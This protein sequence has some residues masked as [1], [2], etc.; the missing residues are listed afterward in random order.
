MGSGKGLTSIAAAEELAK[1]YGLPLEAIM[2]AS[3][4]SNY[5]KEM[6]RHLDHPLEDVR[7]RSYEK[8]VRDKQ[9]NPE[10]FVVLDEAQRA[11][12][13][14]TQLSQ[15]LAKQVQH[16]PA[17]LLLSGTPAYN[18]PV[19]AAR[20]LNLAAGKQ[21]LPDDPYLFNKQFV[22][23]KK[24]SPPLL[25]RIRGMDPAYIPE[26][27]NVDKIIQAAK[28]Y[29]D[30]HPGGGEGFPTSSEEDVEVPMSKEQARMYDFHQGKLPW[31]L[32]V[33][34]RYGMPMSKQESKQLNAFATAI[35]QT[36]NTPRPYIKNMTDE[37]EALNSPKIQRAAE[38]IEKR[39][40]ADP[41]YRGY[42]YSNFLDAGLLPLSRALKGKGIEHGI[43]HGGLSQ[44]EK[45]N[46][47]D[48]YNA[49]K[50]KELLLSSSG[51]EGLDLKGTKHI[52][53]LDPHFNQSKLDQVK[54]RGI[55][56]GSHA[57]L[58][59][60]ERNVQVQRFYSTMPK[61]FFNRVGIGK[62]PMA[63][64][65]YLQQQSGRKHELGQQMM[66]AFQRASDL[67]PLENPQPLHGVK[68]AS[69]LGGALLGGA[70]GAGAS[71]ASQPKEDRKWWKALVSGGVGAGAGGLAGHLMT[72]H[73]TQSYADGMNKAT[74]MAHELL[75]EHLINNLGKRFGG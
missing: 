32:R 75:K 44:E 67:G 57:D 39:L 38:E 2:P 63:I 11:R 5:Q 10:A 49:G 71:L 30:V 41:N 23:E 35:R 70:V 64:D 40:K 15:A 37:E 26:L 53:L 43:F 24:I 34:I 55:R 45:K 72:N 28:G 13:K 62:P 52:A 47:V 7:L 68:A 27:K 25:A 36:S 59:E 33:K 6:N 12:N 9:I 17:R 65:R 29:V 22:G 74:E 61:S 21:V 51:G 46:L 48:R 18:N 66:G 56:F 1:R 8:A 4:I 54:A 31:Y 3:L 42:A 16:A 58:P 19:D 20:L 60:N 69:A 50:L 73:A 14:G